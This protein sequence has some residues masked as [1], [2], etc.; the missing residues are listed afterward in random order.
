[1]SEVDE[2]DEATPSVEELVAG[3]RERAA[4]RVAA[5]EYPR[6]LLSVLDSHFWR[7]VPERAEPIEERLAPLVD[8][9]SEA[10]VF[11]AAAIPSDSQ[12]RLGEQ[13]HRTVAKLVHRQVEGA[14]RQTLTFAVAVDAVVRELARTL[15][16]TRTDVYAQLDTVLERL[17]AYEEAPALP[18]LGRRLDELE[19]RLAPR[20]SWYPLT[21]LADALAD[22]HPGRAAWA[23]EVA[24]A[25]PTTGA[26]PVVLGAH[27][28]EVLDA[29]ATADVEEPDAGLAARAAESGHA[30]LDRPLAAHDDRSRRAVVVVDGLA[31]AELGTPADVVL[32]A[33]DKVEPG[34]RLVVLTG[35]GLWVGEPAPASLFA[36]LARAA[37]FT[38]V[39]RRELGGGGA[40][41]TARR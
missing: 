15:S 22:E 3:V 32:I 7:M 12:S 14:L 39:E 5:G 41:V 27:V 25:V 31:R 36:A 11:D 2:V 6:E 21:A 40:L 24:A 38:E 19:R 20:R 18:E 29:L 30:V 9:V 28:A 16:D 17:A 37:G 1:M 34:G 26:A 10:I 23:D 8:A 4:A 13:V 35:P 33:A